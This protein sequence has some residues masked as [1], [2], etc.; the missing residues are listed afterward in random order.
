MGVGSIPHE[1]ARASIAGQVR[2]VPTRKNSRPAKFR[3]SGRRDNLGRSRTSRRRDRCLHTPLVAQQR[4]DRSVPRC[5]SV[6]PGLV[7]PSE[8]MAPRT[9]S[10][11]GCL[12]VCPGRL[13]LKAQADDLTHLTSPGSR[14]FS[15][16]AHRPAGAPKRASAPDRARRCFLGQGWQRIEIPI[17]SWSPSSDGSTKHLP[18][19][20]KWIAAT[21]MA[22]PISKGPSSAQSGCCAPGSAR[23]RVHCLPNSLPFAASQG[24]QEERAGPGQAANRPSRLANPCAHCVGE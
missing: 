10:S 7:I 16:G 4:C 5:S 18:C 6:V 2:D 12:G 19:S 17:A 8:A 14:A 13:R 20:T 24:P 11:P 3:Q 9:T 22:R 15:A 1:R 23:M 21:R